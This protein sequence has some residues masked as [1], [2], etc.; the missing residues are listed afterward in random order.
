MRA[1]PGLAD[2]ISSGGGETEH[3][4]TVPETVAESFSWGSAV[5][6]LVGELARQIQERLRDRLA[7]AR[8]DHDW[9]L[10]HVIAGTQV[11]VAGVGSPVVL[12]ELEWRRADP[13]DNTAK[14]FRHL[15]EG[16]LPDRVVVAQVFTAKYDLVSGGV[17]SRRQNAEFVGRVAADTFDCLSYA[18]VELAIDPPKRG[19]DLP[20]DWQAAVDDAADRVDDLV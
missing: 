13:V 11:D 17:S 4:R 8:P 20:E 2:W 5:G 10:E 7:A 6:Q 12:V 19:G 16:R 18:P 14:L 3:S 9:R 1:F 15:A